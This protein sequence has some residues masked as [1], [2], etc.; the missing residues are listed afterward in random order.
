MSSATA[1]TRI[2]QGGGG[3]ATVIR[4]GL[5]S[6]LRGFTQ[7]AWRATSWMIAT[8]MSCTVVVL[9]ATHSVATGLSMVGQTVSLAG[10]SGG[11]GAVLVSAAVMVLGVLV[12]FCCWGA[13]VVIK[14]VWRAR[15]RLLISVG[16]QVVDVEISTVATPAGVA[17]LRN[18]DPNHS[19]TDAKEQAK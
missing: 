4:S 7:G 17:V 16:V 3:T 12:G 14:A 6:L 10:A 13:V 2:S 15:V 8:L 11:S 19:E 9:T 1:S 5:K 18:C